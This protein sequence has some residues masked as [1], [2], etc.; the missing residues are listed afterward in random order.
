MAQTQPTDA[1]SPKPACRTLSSRYYWRPE[2][3]EKEKA[4][5]LYHHW[6]YANALGDI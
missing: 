2:I 3:L 5:I 6:H 4:A 1:L